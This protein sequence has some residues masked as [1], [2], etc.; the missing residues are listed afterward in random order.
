M[1]EFKTYL[2]DSVYADIEQGIIRLTTENGY[3][4]TC[5]EIYLE[6]QVFLALIGWFEG[7]KKANAA[8]KTII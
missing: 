5:N 6:P 1:S 4:G 3:G 8:T 7:V 2:G